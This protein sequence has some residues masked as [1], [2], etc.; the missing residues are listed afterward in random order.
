LPTSP[1]NQRIVDDAEAGA[2]LRYPI[3]NT[4]RA[5][6]ATLA[7]KLGAH[8]VTPPDGAFQVELRGYAGQALGF[9]CTDGLAVTLDGFANDTV[10]EA[11]SGG[12]VV[13]RAPASIPAERRAALSL[14][15]NAA[16]YGATG[17]RL[18]VGGRAGQRVGVRNSGATII[19]EGAGKYAFEYMTGGVGVVLGPTGP[20]L[21]SGMTGGVL[22]VLADP[23]ADAIA[24]R[25]HA[26]AMAIS[27]TTE[28]AAALCRL[29]RE[30]LDATGSMTA[31]ALLATPQTLSTRFC[32]I[33]PRPAA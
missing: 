19:V 14:C 22:Y 33:I 9:A 15:G 26:D 29:L 16:A 32:K 2:P 17:G 28:D 24:E 5:V 8:A 27:L 1:L 4:D 18:Y 13:V 6:G 21:G 3:S 30:H 23:S 31:A 10:A 7:G 25:L 12:R 11:M 20:V